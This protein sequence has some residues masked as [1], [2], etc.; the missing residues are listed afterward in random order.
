[1]SIPSTR[2]HLDVSQYLEF[3]KRVLA[4][5]PYISCNRDNFKT[6]SIVLVSVLLDAGSLFD[7]LAQTFIRC[8]YETGLLW[9]AKDSVKNFD[10]KVNR[11]KYFSMAD[12][13]T[14]FE[15]K[16]DFSGKT[17]NLNPY[18]DNFCGYPTDCLRNTLHQFEI[19]PFKEWSSEKSLAWWD[20]FTGLKH[21]RSENLA[22]ATLEN[23]LL[24]AGAAFIVLT[25]FHGDYV[26]T[27]IN[28]IGVL[29]V[30]TPLYWKLRGTR[31]LMQPSFE[32]DVG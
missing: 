25:H 13:Q 4:V 29:Q 12:Y 6:Y 14:L 28:E 31:T 26:K 21:D 7:S 27:R 8:Y 2:C 30:F 11:K 24:A 15:A 16:F 19:C 3:Q 23:T 17:L 1:M 9:E 22:K 10:E 20:A 32:K 18:G 5:F